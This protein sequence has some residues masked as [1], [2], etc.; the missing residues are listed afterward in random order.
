MVFG[1]DYVL[2]NRV[3]DLLW[4]ISLEPFCVNRIEVFDDIFGI[5]LRIVRLRVGRIDY[6][7][8]IKELIDFVFTCTVVMTR[9][10]AHM[11]TKGCTRSSIEVVSFHP[12]AI[13]IS[14]A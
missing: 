5:V 12:D 13:R 2:L 10:P 7:M 1:V 9:T 11:Y 14:D 3:E 8:L 6:S 4:I